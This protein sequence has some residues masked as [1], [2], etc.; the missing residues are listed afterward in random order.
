MVT[1]PGLG[2]AS[3]RSQEFH[4]VS[5]VYARAPSTWAAF[6]YLPR[7]IDRER[8]GSLPAGTLTGALT[9]VSVSPASPP[10]QPLKY[11]EL[12]FATE[13]ER[14]AVSAWQ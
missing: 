12:D 7:R 2:Q 9:W 11:F 1:K 14:I 5:Y 13:I 3:A 4:P 6:C 10:C 8:D